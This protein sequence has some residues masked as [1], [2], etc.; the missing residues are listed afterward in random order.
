LHRKNIVYPLSAISQTNHNVYAIAYKFVYYNY[1]THGV[2]TGSVN[3]RYEP[4]HD[5]R[6]STWRIALNRS[7]MPF[8]KFK[9]RVESLVLILMISIDLSQDTV[10][11]RKEYSKM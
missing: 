3:F 6:I 7:N 8:F 4:I 9:V 5:V 2:I 10:R 1:T 11:S